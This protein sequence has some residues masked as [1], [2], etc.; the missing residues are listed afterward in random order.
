[1]GQHAGLLSYIHIVFSPEGLEKL[2]KLHK[3]HGGVWAHDVLEALKAV[4]PTAMPRPTAPR[5]ED[6]ISPNRLDPK[7]PYYVY[8]AL[9]HCIHNT[10]TN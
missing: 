7:V 1:M 4:L 5:T 2:H 6:T 9:W 8:S 10:H 3:T